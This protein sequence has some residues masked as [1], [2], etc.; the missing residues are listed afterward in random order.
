[1]MLCICTVAKIVSY[2]FNLHVRL[3]GM[4][5]CILYT[6]VLFLSEKT[7]S[8]LQKDM[9]RFKAVTGYKFPTLTR[10]PNCGDSC[11]VMAF[12][13]AGDFSNSYN[14]FF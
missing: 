14:S 6:R 11:Q 2:K 7:S 9:F 1:M 12:L 4:I 8:S 13:C 5:F 10:V 3:F